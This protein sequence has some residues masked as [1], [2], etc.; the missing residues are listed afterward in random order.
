M[1]NN[2]QF[3]RKLEENEK[4]RRT[5]PRGTNKINENSLERLK[6][7]GNSL[8]N[9]NITGNGL[10]Q[11]TTL[12]YPFWLICSGILFLVMLKGS[13]KTILLNSFQNFI[14]IDPS[15][16]SRP[17]RRAKND[18]C[19]GKA[20]GRRWR[21]R[22][23]S[24][25]ESFFDLISE[26]K[27]A[28]DKLFFHR[29]WKRIFVETFDGFGALQTSADKRTKNCFV[30]LHF[31]PQKVNMLNGHSQCFINHIHLKHT[32]M[33]NYADVKIHFKVEYFLHFH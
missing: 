2:D 3:R 20:I 10:K 31:S 30:F 11:L 18:Q 24:S 6:K 22:T 16:C 21:R 27:S 32:K 15:F 8:W 7:A 1:S 19:S 12:F 5:H 28:L 4:I 25:I 33:T 17:K 26:G 9:E 13:V 14:S 29:T 23:I